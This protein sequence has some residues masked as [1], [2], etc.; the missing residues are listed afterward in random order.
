MFDPLHPQIHPG[1]GNAH[2]FLRLSSLALV[3][4]T[5]PLPRLHPAFLDLI[6]FRFFFFF[7]LK[8]LKST[9]YYLEH[10]G[11]VQKLEWHVGDIAEPDLGVGGPT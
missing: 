11:D 2:V 4:D 3:H 10:L 6:Y 7:N 8:E 1:E 9:A 5:L